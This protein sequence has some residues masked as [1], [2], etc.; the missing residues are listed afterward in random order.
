MTEH[1]PASEYAKVMRK[2]SHTKAKP[3]K[4]AEGYFASGGE[5]EHWGMLKLQEKAGVI[6][7]LKCKERIPLTVN[8]VLI[9]TYNSDFTYWDVAS[10]RFVFDDYKGRVFREW[11]LTKKLLT[12]LFPDAII[13]ESGSHDRKKRR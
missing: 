1:V 12:A 3:V 10:G 8:G 4:T 11:Q 6:R 13:I 9:K 5:H 2:K 7:D